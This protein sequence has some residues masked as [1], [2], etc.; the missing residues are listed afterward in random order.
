MEGPKL[1]AEGA[2]GT[3]DGDEWP[4]TACC[5]LG[6]CDSADRRARVLEQAA[7]RMSHLSRRVVAGEVDLAGQD[8]RRL[9]PKPPLGRR[10]MRERPGHAPG[11]RR[12]GASACP[13]LG[14]ADRWAPSRYLVTGVN[15]LGG[16]A[17]LPLEIA[18]QADSRTGRSADPHQVPS[19]D[20]H[21]TADGGRARMAGQG[22]RLERYSRAG[23]RSS[24]V[25]SLWTPRL[26]R[27]QARQNEP[28]HLYVRPSCVDRHLFRC[29]RPLV[30]PN[31]GGAY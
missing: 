30:R 27:L 21:A 28:D 22:P 7:G 31:G 18:W 25:E 24:R 5:G 20:R 6:I 23:A 10:T 16:P 9:C 3:E 13:R 1:A 14:S 2:K 15:N 12:G 19:R 11:V 4:R 26:G 8:R 29:L 17:Q